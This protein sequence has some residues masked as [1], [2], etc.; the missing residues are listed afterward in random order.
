M[1]ATLEDVQKLLAENRLRFDFFQRI[2]GMPVTLKP[3]AQ[4]KC[5]IFPLIEAFTKKG[6][7]LAFELGA[8][9]HVLEHVWPGNT[10]ELKRFV[11]L[12]AAG[13]HGIVTLEAVRKHITPAAAPSAAAP[14]AVGP[15][16]TMNTRLN[17]AWP[18]PWTAL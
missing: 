11:E 18:R 2:H 3:L 14:E 8:K 1:S 15:A 6:K 9:D 10:R 4:R 13:A 5:D 12:V 7:R 16:R 17:T